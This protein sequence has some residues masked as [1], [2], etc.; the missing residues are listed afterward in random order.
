[1]SRRWLMVLVCCA[2]CGAFVATSDGESS[3]VTHRTQSNT[4][5][6]PD[7]M[8]V[9]IESI[10]RDIVI[11]DPLG[12]VCEN[13]GLV[14]VIPECVVTCEEFHRPGSTKNVPRWLTSYSFFEPATGTYNVRTGDG[15]AWLEWV[16]VQA[17]LDTGEACGGATDTRWE[18]PS[19]WIGS[20]S[21]V[22]ERQEEGD[23]CSI[24]ILD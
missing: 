6:I 5:H 18:I 2:G 3:D 4:P 11:M 17:I 21:F 22:Y 9:Q 23:S 12:R 24:R 19:T 14:N 15:G 10:S 7:R 13:A 1:M 16:A 8:A 20:C